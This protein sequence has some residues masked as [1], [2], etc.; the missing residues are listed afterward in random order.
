MNPSVLLYVLKNL[1]RLLH[2]FVPFV[3]ETLWRH[4]EQKNLLMAEEWPKA[5][6]KLVFPKEEKEFEAVMELIGAIRSIRAE[7]G[8]EP[9]RRISA[10]IYG[11]KLTHVLESKREPLMKLARLQELKIETKGAKIKGAIWK[12]VGGMDVYLPAQD[13]FDISKEK[14][15][16]KT[17]LEETSRKMKSIE[18]RINN[19]G[20]LQNAPEQVVAKEKL[21]FQELENELRSLEEKINELESLQ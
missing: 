16:L 8:V 14:E 11:G 4:I 3:T 12:Y 7:K 5:N 20:F 18:G 1:L 15:R 6:P 13:L 21:L 9:A 17:K 19:P 2:P 10:V